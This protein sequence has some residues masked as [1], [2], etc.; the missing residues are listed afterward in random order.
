M[1]SNGNTLRI[2]DTGLDEVGGTEIYS[3]VEYGSENDLIPLGSSRLN[4]EFTVNT[5]D[6]KSTRLSN[7]ELDFVSNEISSVLPPRWQV[8]GL[9]PAS[10]VEQ[11][12]AIRKLQTTLGI[13]ELTGGLGLI[14]AMPE[15]QTGTYTPQNGSPTTYDFIH[16]I[17][18]NVTMAE[19]LSRST[20]YIQ[21]TIQ[22]EQVK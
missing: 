17:V 8:N 7:G 15:K 18:K 6:Y 14:S 19:V 11:I 13:K 3:K 4:S 9:I 12:Q 1:E 2:R 10:N 5:T 22:L 20:E 21:V 16:V